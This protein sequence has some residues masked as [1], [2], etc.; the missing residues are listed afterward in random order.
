MLSDSGSNVDSPFYESPRSV[1]PYGLIA[2]APDHAFAPRKALL[3]SG[4]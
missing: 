3:P 1:F 4:Y 2:V